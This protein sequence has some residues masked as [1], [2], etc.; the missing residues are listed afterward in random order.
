MIWRDVGCEKKYC[1]NGKTERGGGGELN[2]GG[3]LDSV[4]N[5][6]DGATG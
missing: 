1:G 2:G 3:G 6:S 5:I 4:Y